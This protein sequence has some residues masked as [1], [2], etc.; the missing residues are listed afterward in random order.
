MKRWLPWATTAVVVLLEFL[1]MIVV[2]V[3]VAPLKPAEFRT[4]AG[5]SK[6]I[7]EAHS[8]FLGVV[9]TEWFFFLL[10][11]GVIIPVSVIILM[12]LGR[13]LLDKRHGV[14]G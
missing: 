10:T 7:T 5:Y 11:A 13:Y 14:H 8:T 4:D 9:I 6:F 2:F 12:E 3:N 1:L